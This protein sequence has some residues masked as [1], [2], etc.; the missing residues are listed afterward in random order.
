[1]N[2][3]AR[4]LTLAAGDRILCR[5]LD[6]TLE[7][8]EVIAVLGRN[9]SGKTTLVHTLGGVRPPQHGAVELDAR[10]LAD[11]PRR[12][13]GRAIGILPQFEDQAYWGTVRDYVMLG[14]YPHARSPFGWSAGDEAAV[15]QAL[16]V[17]GLT[18]L[19]GRTFVSLSGGERQRARIAQ[20]WAQDPRFM[21]LDEP[22]QHL[23]LQHQLH[24]MEVAR[25]AARAGKGI[26]LVLHDL[27]WAGRCDR[28]LLLFGNGRHA[29]GAACDML[30]VEQLEELYGCSLRA[31]GHGTDRHFLPVI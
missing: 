17:V 4:G 10:L 15:D 13:L 18:A 12:G 21:L 30:E 20:L 9:G 26:I 14:R 6:L 2:L 19:A 3:C 31:F 11:Y 8:G 16:A 23:D 25:S 5:A 24:V 27:A 28:A 1:V 22:L 29:Y 7:P